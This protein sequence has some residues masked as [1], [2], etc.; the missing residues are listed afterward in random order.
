MGHAAVEG[1]FG[2]SD[3]EREDGDAPLAACEASDVVRV[4][5]RNHGGIEAHGGRDDERIDG[6]R[7]WQF[8]LGEQATSDASKLLCQLDNNES[9][10]FQ[11]VIGRRV[12]AGAA[13]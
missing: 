9:A 2:Q 1:K 12:E 6:M 4:R 3:S 13:V 8:G 7:G 11:E 5:S 10:R